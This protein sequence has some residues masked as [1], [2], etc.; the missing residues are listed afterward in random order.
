MYNIIGFSKI[1]KLLLLMRKQKIKERF[2]NVIDAFFENDVRFED[3]QIAL[4]NDSTLVLDDYAEKETT[5]KI[6]STI[7]YVK[8]IFLF[9]PGSFFLFKVSLIFAYIT[10]FFS[11][12][13]SNYGKFEYFFVE[14]LIKNSYLGIFFSLA[15]CFMVFIGVGSIKET[16]NLI[17]PGLI[18]SFSM[19][20]FG[21][22][23]FLPEPFRGDV[24]QYYS[25]YLFP[26]V[27][28]G[29]GFVKSWIEEKVNSF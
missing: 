1:G 22:F 24:V 3:A 28:V 7:S 6:D 19:L 5:R 4:N 21:V 10:T 23:T 14:F 13:I 25:T 16:K 20:L 8:M 18:I 27:L 15:A 2:E 29:V 9:L 26:L 12:T 17:A 11:H